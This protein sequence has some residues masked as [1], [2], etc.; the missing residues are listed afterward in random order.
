MDNENLV[1]V[2]D[3]VRHEAQHFAARTIKIYKYII[4]KG[5]QKANMAH[6][7]ISIIEYEKIRALEEVEREYGIGLPNETDWW[8]VIPRN[9]EVPDWQRKCWE[10]F[11]KEYHRY[12]EILI[13]MRI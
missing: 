4:K 1:R 13:K 5:T 9:G 2:L 7:P 11:D 12:L 8:W 6:C 3:E 10:E